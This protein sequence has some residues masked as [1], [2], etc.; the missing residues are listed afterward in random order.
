M[1]INHDEFEDQ[2]GLLRGIK[3]R[4]LRTQPLSEEEMK[5]TNNYE[6]EYEEMRDS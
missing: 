1:L 4:R 6:N 5:R 2:T 3:K